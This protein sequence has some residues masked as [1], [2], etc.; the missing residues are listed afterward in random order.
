MSVQQEFANALYQLMKWVRRRE[1]GDE[2]FQDV[3]NLI[4]PNSIAPGNIDG[5][6]NEINEKDHQLR[7]PN[8]INKKIS[9]KIVG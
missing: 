3:Q 5:G 4:N 7:I 2:N 6:Q 1:E 8:G 9:N